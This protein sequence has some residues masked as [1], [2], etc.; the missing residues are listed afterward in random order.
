[1][2]RTNVVSP[3]A[4][5]A[6]VLESPGPGK[7]REATHQNE[8][9]GPPPGRGILDSLFLRGPLKRVIHF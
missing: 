4:T 5:K 6:Y 9:R 3:P 2:C 1:M 8:L 7:G